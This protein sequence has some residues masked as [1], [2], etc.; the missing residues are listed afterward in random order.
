[1]RGL[2]R[3]GFTA[4]KTGVAVALVGAMV[5]L[6]SPAGAAPATGVSLKYGRNCTFTVKASWTPVTGQQSITLL[7]K[8]VTNTL[9]LG[10]HVDVGARAKSASLR[11]TAI[12]LAAG[13]T[14]HVFSAIAELRPNADGS[15]SP[16]WTA[17]LPVEDQLSEPCE[18]TS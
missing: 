2:R 5:S 8:D 7:I 15:G 10:T 3:R 11:L 14:N 4:I 13:E 1:M 6:A 18:V 17:T 12:P 9:M 16:L